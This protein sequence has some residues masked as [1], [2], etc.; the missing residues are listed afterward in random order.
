MPQ[1][2]WLL[3]TTEGKVVIMLALRPWPLW[4]LLCLGM[5]LLTACPKLITEISY[6]Y[7]LTK[8]KEANTRVACCLQFERYL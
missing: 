4:G 1:R 2:N 3:D 6:N 8:E 5:L 7:L